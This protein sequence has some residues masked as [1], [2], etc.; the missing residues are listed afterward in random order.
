MI[1]EQIPF[2]RE[3]ML[4]WALTLEGELL[5][6]VGWEGIRGQSARWDKST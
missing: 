5:K 6:A 4:G 3:A 2:L 1:E